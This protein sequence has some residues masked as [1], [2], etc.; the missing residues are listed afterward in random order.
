M[1]CFRPHLNAQGLTEQQW[2]VLRALAEV[3][4]I[5]IGALSDW[6]ALLMPSLS[7]IL[8]GLEKN[9][10]INR[11]RD[12]TDGR[13]VILSLTSDGRALFEAMSCTSEDI[14]QT[15]ERTLGSFAISE[16]MGEL[17]RLIRALEATKRARIRASEA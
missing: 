8:P 4:E 3:D 13:V 6:I 1:E 9:G 7:R 2:R 11:R 17:D 12:Q 15:L 16:L 14:Y 10:L 5:D